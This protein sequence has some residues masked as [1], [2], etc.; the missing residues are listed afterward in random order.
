MHVEVPGRP[1]WETDL[2]D[3]VLE[4]LVAQQ[5]WGGAEVQGP[6]SWQGTPRCWGQE[7]GQAGT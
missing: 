1:V 5:G 2:W 6:V 7:R 4:T 3:P